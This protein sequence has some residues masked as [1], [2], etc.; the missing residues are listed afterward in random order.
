MSDQQH[1]IIDRLRSNRAFAF[2]DPVLLADAVNAIRDLST[3]LSR[4]QA[5]GGEP[6][7]IQPNHLQ[8]ARK[9]P[10]L[11]RVAPTQVAPDFVPLYAP[12]PAAPEGYKDWAA[13]YRSRIT[14]WMTADE[15][16]AE[17]AKLTK[18]DAGSPELLLIHA[19]HL[20][21]RT[22]AP[23]LVPLSRIDELVKVYSKSYA[24]PHHFVMDCDGVRKIINGLTV[25]EKGG[26]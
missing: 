17:V 19:M 13:F 5:A 4:L 12:P 16:R 8:M 26:A 22:A 10:M 14:Q 18:T 24:S 15:L 9:A 2:A 21:D 25:G 1:D 7:W 6:V 20:I 3:E 23:A 11:C